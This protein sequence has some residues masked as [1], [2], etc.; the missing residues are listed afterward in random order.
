MKFGGGFEPP[1]SHPRCDV[2]PLHYPEMN[3][4][5][6]FIH[7][8]NIIFGLYIF[9]EPEKNLFVQKTGDVLGSPLNDAKSTPKAQFWTI[10]SRY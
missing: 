4:L 10:H 5:S 8:C 1:L 6:T 7:F 2:L 9:G 3:E